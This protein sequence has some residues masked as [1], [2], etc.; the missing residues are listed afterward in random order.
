MN[1]SKSA[2]PNEIAGTTVRKA[3]I[4]TAGVIAELTSNSM[5]ANVMVPVSAVTIVVVNPASTLTLTATVQTP[6][7]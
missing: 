2:M 7:F 4:A 1:Y 5:G 3:L 6:F